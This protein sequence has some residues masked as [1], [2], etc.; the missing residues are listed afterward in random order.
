MRPITLLLTALLA[1]APLAVAQAP[2]PAAPMP[3]IL[4][5]TNGDQL[6]GKLVSAAG[7]NIVFASDMAGQLTIPFS[8]IKELRSGSSPAQFALLKKGVPVNAA[9]PRA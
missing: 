9:H 7:G 5:F 4:I 1:A 2:T 3:D 8:K 6:T